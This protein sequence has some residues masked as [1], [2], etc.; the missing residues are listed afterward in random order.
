L[1]IL[2]SAKKPK[3]PKKAKDPKKLKILTGKKH[4]VTKMANKEFVVFMVSNPKEGEVNLFY[5]Q[6][7]GNE[8]RLTFLKSLFDKCCMD[9]LE[10]TNMPLMYLDTDNKLSEEVVDAHMKIQCFNGYLKMFNKCEGIFHFST[11]ED[12]KEE[13][14]ALDKYELGLELWKTF[15]GCKIEKFYNKTN[16][17]L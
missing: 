17:W 14:F 6:W 9:D 13:W 4:Q 7:T 10:N 11:Y 8:E 2:Y 1:H 15:R 12:V 16:Q 3:K 5:L